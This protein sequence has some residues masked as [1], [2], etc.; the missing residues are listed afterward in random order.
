LL[1]VT[2][3]G[4]S[5]NSVSLMT[6]VLMDPPEV[7]LVVAADEEE[8][9]SPSEPYPPPPP[10]E[11]SPVDA[12]PEVADPLAEDPPEPAPPPQLVSARAST[13]ARAA[14]ASVPFI[15][16]SLLAGEVRLAWRVIRCA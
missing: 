14:T 5:L 15:V 7:P 9:D 12:L 10:L 1:R 11:D 6:T 3:E 2:L 16:L 13:R 4:E 8:P